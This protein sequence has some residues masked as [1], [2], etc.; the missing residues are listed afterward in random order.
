MSLSTRFDRRVGPISVATAP[1]FSTRRPILRSPS[2]A[3]RAPVLLLVTAWRLPPH[4]L[5]SGRS[6]ARCLDTQRVG[7]LF[8]RERTAGTTNKH[9]L[10][11]ATQGDGADQ[12]PFGRRRQMR[13]RVGGCCCRRSRWRVRCGVDM[14]FNE[15]GGKP[16]FLGWRGRGRRWHFWRMGRGRE[17]S[18]DAA[19]RSYCE[20]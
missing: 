16:G 19:G 14:F 20:V 8:S 7:S 15:A 18:F 3:L 13:S 10:M 1:L 4:A 9:P 5:Q 2:A 11:L 17:F 12:C 6:S